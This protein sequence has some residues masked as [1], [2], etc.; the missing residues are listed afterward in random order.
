[1]A[2]GNQPVLCGL[3]SKPLDC[4]KSELSSTSP[5]DTAEEILTSTALRSYDI[6]YPG[7]QRYW[8]LKLLTHIWP[9]KYENAET[10]FP[11]DK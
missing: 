3:I 4:L 8:F 6:W 7:N 11:K 1:M 2:L 5:Q 10:F 9:E